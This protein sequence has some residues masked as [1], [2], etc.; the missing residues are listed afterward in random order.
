M[1]PYLS[2]AAFRIQRRSSAPTDFLAFPGRSHLLIAEP[3]WEA[4]A[5]ACIA[6][7]APHRSLQSDADFLKAP[8]GEFL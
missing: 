6:W 1:T 8:E 5:Q 3:G 4:V 7:D 2:R